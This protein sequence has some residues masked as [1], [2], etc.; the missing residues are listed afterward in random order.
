MI[1]A[2]SND[3]GSAGKFSFFHLAIIASVVNTFN[4][5]ISLVNGIFL[6]KISGNQVY[7]HNSTLSFAENAPIYETNAEANKASPMTERIFYYNSFTFIPHLRF[8]PAKPLTNFSAAS[9]LS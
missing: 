6:S 7:F 8:S 4:G 9:N 3:M 1:E 2:F 5:V